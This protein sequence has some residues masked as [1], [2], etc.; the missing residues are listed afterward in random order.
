MI[1]LTGAT[2]KLGSAVLKELLT[3][4]PPSEITVSLHN[5]SAMEDI[6]KTGV[7]VKIADYTQPKTLEEAFAGADKLLLVSHPSY[8][9]EHLRIASHK[10]AIDAAKKVG[11]KHIYY[12][13][14]TYAS[15]STAPI[16]KAHVETEKYLKSSGVT[17]TIIREGLYVD[18]YPVFFGF[19]NP[20]K[21]NKVVLPGDGGIAYATIEDLGKGTARI[22]AKGGYENQEISLTGPKAY[23]SKEVASVISSILGREISVVIT[24]QKE[25]LK[26][27]STNPE[28]EYW[29]LAF[30]AIEKGECATV[31]PLLE[32]LL[33]RPLVSFETRMKE[34]LYA[35]K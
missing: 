5:T 35:R 24:S 29:A 2:G 11:V 30:P 34:I 25:F 13:S 14:L 12:T 9:D 28:A 1:V 16:M 6:N 31:D 27:Y 32:N 7:Q 23:T 10:N 17:Y 20:S 4:V 22:L 33:G 3:L 8:V 15:D 21:D 18:V 19:F 26:Y